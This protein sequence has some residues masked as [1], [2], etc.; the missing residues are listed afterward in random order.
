MNSLNPRKY[1]STTALQCFEA[2][3]R[4]L[5]FTKAGKE[6]HMTQSAVSKQIAQLEDLLGVQLF[7]RT[8]QGICLSPNGQA[9]YIESLKILQQLEAAT[10]SMMA[11]K[12]EIQTLSIACHPT[13]CAKWLIPCLKGFGTAHPW[14][15]LD[16][17]ETTQ[18]LLDAQDADMAFLFGDGVWVDM[19]AIK[20]FDEYCIAV[21]QP[22]YL[23][24]HTTCQDLT[25]YPLLQIS[26]RPN[27]WYDYFANQKYHYN[28][29]ITGAKFDTFHACINAAIIGCGIALVP[30]NFVQQELE[31]GMLTTALPYK[32]PSQSAY[33]MAY[34]TKTANTPKIQSMIQWVHQ[35]SI[36]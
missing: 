4:H 20:L 36:R 24:Q 31:Q 28:Q 5:S 9:Y 10:L 3:A 17:K 2:S 16:I 18:P 15:H 6:M 12:S 13:F 8:N 29:V 34:Q 32:M 19:D 7:Y 23:P 27:A 33:Y 1:P 25:N 21:C 14:I 30:M 26:S 35:Q 11:K 22:N